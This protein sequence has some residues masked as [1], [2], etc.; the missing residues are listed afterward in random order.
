MTLGRK[1]HGVAVQQSAKK[2]DGNL[3]AKRSIFALKCRR[4]PGSSKALGNRAAHLG[5][6]R[7]VELHGL[8]EG[9]REQVFASCAACNSASCAFC[10]LF[11]ET[12]AFLIS[13]VCSRR[14]ERAMAAARRRLSGIQLRNAFSLVRSCHLI[15]RSCTLKPVLVIVL[16]TD[17]TGRSQNNLMMM[18]T[19]N[20]LK[21]DLAIA[22]RWKR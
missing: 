10:A 20:T 12:V 15:I 11:R 16:S 6:A 9:P 1:L 7:L 8:H 3:S 13:E 14:A 2:A 5:G 19:S 21:V 4:K 17:A 22:Q 18:M